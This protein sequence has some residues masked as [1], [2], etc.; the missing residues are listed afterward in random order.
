[1]NGADQFHVAQTAFE[2]LFDAGSQFFGRHF[3]DGVCFVAIDGNDCVGQ[4]F[5]QGQQGDG[6]AV[7]EAFVSGMLVG[8]GMLHAADK[9]GAAVIVHIG[10]NAQLSAGLGKAAVCCQE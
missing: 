7:V 10:G 1:M 4:M 8:Q 9:H 5:L 3:F 6:A 2:L